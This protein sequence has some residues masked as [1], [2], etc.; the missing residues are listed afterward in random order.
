MGWS[1]LSC[2]EQIGQVE[3]NGFDV[4][5]CT[6]ICRSCTKGVFTIHMYVHVV[7][8]KVPKFGEKVSEVNLIG[9]NFAFV[10]VL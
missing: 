1:Y 10:C 4:D 2:L 9:L 3:K 6:D 7:V 5:E 8:C